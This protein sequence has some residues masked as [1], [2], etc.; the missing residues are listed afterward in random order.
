MTEIKDRQTNHKLSM[1]S[2]RRNTR[3][4]CDRLE[5]SKYVTKGSKKN[6]R[7]IPQDIEKLSRIIFSN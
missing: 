5:C 3:R 6:R 1:I 7:G 2:L 4:R